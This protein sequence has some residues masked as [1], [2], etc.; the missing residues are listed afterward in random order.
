[1]D[2]LRIR[3]TLFR[4][5]TVERWKMRWLMRMAGILPPPLVYWAAMRLIV[6]ASTGEWGG[7]VVPELPAMKA[8]ERW[9]RTG[10]GRMSR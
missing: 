2:R 9:E 4:S 8:M 1:M 6:H 3:W 10:L 5:G 7:Q